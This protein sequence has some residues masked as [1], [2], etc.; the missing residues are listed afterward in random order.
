MSFITRRNVLKTSAVFALATPAVLRITK[1][2]AAEFIMKLANDTPVTHPLS[3]RMQEAGEAIRNETNGKVEIRVFP[4]NQLGSDTDMLTQV[5]S[6]ALE[7]FS[8]SPLIL[9]TLVPNAAVSGIGFAWKGYEKLWPAMDGDLGAY[10]RGQIAKAGL[11]AFDK[12]WENGFRQTTS[13]TRQILT[14]DDLKGFKI[15]VPVSPLWT[16]MFKALDASPMSINFSE[17]YSAL[18]TKIAEGQ[19]NP[20]ALIDTA[21]LYEVQKYLSKTNHMWDGF[22][23][24]ANGRNWKA[25]P[26]DVQQ[27]IAKNFNDKAV[28]QREDVFKLNNSLE[29][30][31]ADKGM[32]IASVETAP[33]RQK[34]QSS[35]FYK[36]WREKFGPEAWA[37]LEKHAGAIS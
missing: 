18:Q 7:F 11:Y 26:A 25:L 5:R 36:E 8:L 6:G 15:R 22:W 12:I 33:F 4:N 27:V 21:K 31:L 37:L 2:H 20:I 24:L 14:P 28:L 32:T 3:T 34:L 17:V 10:V 13:S 35:G 30:E 16:S 9:Q 29:K 1:L 19:E 23:L